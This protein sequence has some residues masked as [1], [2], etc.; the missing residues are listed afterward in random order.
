L[1]ASASKREH[2]FGQLRDRGFSREALARVRSPVGVPLGA[3]SPAEIAVSIVA[4][5]VREMHPSSLGTSTR[6]VSQVT[7]NPDAVSRPP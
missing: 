1:I 4:E 2:M 3:E 5:I 7:P 6:E